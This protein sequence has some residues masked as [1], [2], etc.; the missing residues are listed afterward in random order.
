MLI[1]IRSV[2]TIRHLWSASLVLLLVTLV[3]PVLAHAHG[4]MG[5]DEVG[6]P[7]VTSGLLGFASYW[8]VML[9]PWSRKNDD[10]GADT[11]VPTVSQPGGAKRSGRIKR[12]PPRLRKVEGTG[13]S[14]VEPNARRKASDG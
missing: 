9:W 10:Q 2:S 13:Q 4:G 7:L 14:R 5:P 6:P 11:G 1:H 12:L 3:L 8:V